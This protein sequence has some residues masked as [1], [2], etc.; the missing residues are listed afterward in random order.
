MSI[1]VEEGVKI[2]QISPVQYKVESFIITLSWFG[3]LG[4]A[5]LIMSVFFDLMNSIDYDLDIGFATFIRKNHLS[6]RNT[7]PF[8]VVFSDSGMDKFCAGFAMIVFFSILGIYAYRRTKALGSGGWIF[9]F[10]LVNTTTAGLLIYRGNLI[11]ASLW[12]SYW[13]VDLARDMYMGCIIGSIVLSIPGI[14]SLRIF[15]QRSA[16]VEASLKIML[17]GCFSVLISTNFIMTYRLMRALPVQS[18]CQWTMIAAAFVV[19]SI[20]LY[21]RFSSP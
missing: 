3:I 12:M 21:A 9:M 10:I 7:L 15:K 18:V 11:N 14:W 4:G 5:F 6:F 2:I 8:T 1:N 16:A 20:G 19:I 13:S 17:W